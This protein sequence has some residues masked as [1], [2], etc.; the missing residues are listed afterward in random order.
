MVVEIYNKRIEHKFLTLR[1]LVWK[2][3][4]PHSTK[5]MTFKGKWYMI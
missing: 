4:L 5:D 2:V 3:N 1:D